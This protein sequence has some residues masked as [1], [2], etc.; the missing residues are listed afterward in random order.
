MGAGPWH[1]NADISWLNSIH[2]NIHSG[3]GMGEH[4]PTGQTGEAPV[5]G[6]LLPAVQPQASGFLSLSFPF[7]VKWGGGDQ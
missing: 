1:G 5:P 2:P 3:H 4:E 7:I 6:P